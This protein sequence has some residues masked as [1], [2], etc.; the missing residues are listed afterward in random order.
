[1]NHHKS[2]NVP[3]ELWAAFSIKRDGE[4]YGMA[5]HYRPELKRQHIGYLIDRAK[6]ENSGLTLLLEDGSREEV[7]QRI[8]N[9]K[10]LK[11]MK[12]TPV[13]K[14]ATIIYSK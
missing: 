4:E 14:P 11:E 12:Y 9:L 7:Q 6:Q 1:M 5:V 2:D 8:A 13:Q 10:P 3:R